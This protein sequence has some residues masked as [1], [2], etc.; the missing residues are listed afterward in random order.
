[1]NHQPWCFT[2]PVNEQRSS[3]VKLCSFHLFDKTFRSPPL[4]PLLWC[5]I[6]SHV[7]DTW[8]YVEK[9]KCKRV[10]CYFYQKLSHTNLFKKNFGK[11]SHWVLQSKEFNPENL[12]TSAITLKRHASKQERHRGNHE[13]LSPSK[14]TGKYA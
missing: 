11:C 10:A 4:K 13:E 14:S 6:G 3:P 2:S 8:Y 12:N 1:M 7:L 9:Y 5:E